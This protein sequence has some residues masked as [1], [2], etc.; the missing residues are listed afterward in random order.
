METMARPS[1]FDSSFK[2][3]VALEALRNESTLSDLAK[4]YGVAP[5]VITVWR[6]ELLQNAGRAFEKESVKESELKREKAKNER[7]LKT[8]GQLKVEVDFFAQA[9]EDA[10]LDPK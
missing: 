4:K 5:S 3:K 9:C 6:E 7:L 2:A 10:G 1:K 8:I